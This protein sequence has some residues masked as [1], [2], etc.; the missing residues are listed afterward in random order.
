MTNKTISINPLLFR[1]SN[2]TKRNDKKT[3]IST[4][5]LSNK[6]IKNRLLKRIKEHKAQ[7]FKNS[8][9]SNNNISVENTNINEFDSS[10]QYLQKM[11][12]LEDMKRQQEILH[13]KTIKN[14][15]SIH[16]PNEEDNIQ[17]ETAEIPYGNL[18]GGFKPTYREW[19]KTFK[20]KPDIITPIQSNK[21]E[22]EKR[23]LELRE[24]I[25]LKKQMLLQPTIS[26]PSINIQSASEP[27]TDNTPSVNETNTNIS[28]IHQPTINIQSIN[29]PNINI[30]QSTTNQPV[31]RLLKKTIRKKY[32]IGKSSDKREIGVL[33]KDNESRS[34]I[35][36]IMKSYK[37]K[38]INEIK[39]YLREHNIIKIGSNAPDDI[40]RKMYENIMLTGEID[41]INKDTI[42]YNLKNEEK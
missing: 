31:K 11:K 25:K 36:N 42:L 15:I 32:L 9:L 41:N 23:I 20:I 12:E 10:I 34:N 18:K 28:T 2:K 22:R 35:I 17:T 26:I 4:D 24:K 37:N 29:E 5:G 14:H 8:E 40:L 3:N 7:E 33:L 1:I 39:K 30:S 13:K 38:P 19:N 6:M 16:L 21:N 27:T